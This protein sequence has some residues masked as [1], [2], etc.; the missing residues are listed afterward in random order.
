LIVARRGLSAI[1]TTSSPDARSSSKAQGRPAQ[2][3]HLVRQAARQVRQRATL[4][5][6]RA[7]QTRGRVRGPRA[8]VELHNVP[9]PARQMR[10][11]AA[12]REMR[13]V[14]T[15]RVVLQRRR[16]DVSVETSRPL[17]CERPFC[18][19]RRRT[20][21]WG[22][23]C[24]AVPRRAGCH[25]CHG[26]ASRLLRRHFRRLADGD[27]SKRRNRTRGGRAALSRPD[28]S[29]AEV[30]DVPSYTLFIAP[31]N[32]SNKFLNTQSRYR[33]IEVGR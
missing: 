6:V 15:G 7:A 13:R 21:R 33:W 24:R 17:P 3:V 12:V 26:R 22:S 31:W 30:D 1:L 8:Q 28:W 19:R 23:A 4:R 32:I 11:G 10:Q 29:A 20:Q 27:T 5:A 18:P 25:A 16:H 9:A 14:A 2:G